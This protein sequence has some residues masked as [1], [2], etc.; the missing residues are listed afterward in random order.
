MADLTLKQLRTAMP[1]ATLANCQ[2][3]LQPL[4]DAMDKYDINTPL[5]QA[6]FL[7]QVAWESGS[8]RY[9]REIA[10]GKA[11]EGRKDLGNVKPGW[12]VRYK[13]RGLIQVT[14]HANYYRYGLIIGKDME[15][16][17]QQNWLL[18]EQPQWAADSAGW[19][20]KAN[21]LNER[22]DRDEHTNITRIING[23]TRTAASRLPYLRSAK[24]ALGLIKK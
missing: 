3:F 8:L 10:S 9:T 23:S 11:Y 14:G 2:K 15:D 5:R 7:C 6:H 21:H 1:Y 22:A 24:I 13:G 4:N 19:F 18:L 12:G 16:E 20:W 17:K